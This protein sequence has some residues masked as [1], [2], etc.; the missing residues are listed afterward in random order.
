MSE[1]NKNNL[2]YSLSYIPLVAFFFLFTEKEISKE[3][4][5]HINY[6]MILFWIYII[7]SFILKI[8]FLFFLSYLL[9]ILYIWLSIYLWFKIYNW[10]DFQVDILD[11]IEEKVSDNFWKK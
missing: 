5:K 8:L 10:N 9:F 7:L 1:I 4:K 2:K 11:N 6:G 3:F